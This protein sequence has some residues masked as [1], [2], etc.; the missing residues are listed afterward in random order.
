[1]ARTSSEEAYRSFLAGKQ[2][3]PFRSIDEL[4]E[5]IEHFKS[6]IDADGNFARAWAW[7]SYSYLSAHVEGLSDGTSV[8]PDFLERARLAADKAFQLDPYDYDT[9]WALAEMHIY[10]GDFDGAIKAFD[11]ALWLNDDNNKNL[12]VDVAYTSIYAGALDRA[13]ELIAKS[14]IIWDWNRCALAFAYY[15]KGRTEPGCYQKALAEIE[16]MY[17]QPGDR[18]YIV[19]ALKVRA[20]ASARLAEAHHARSK[21]LVG[22]GRRELAEAERKLELA[23]E[24]DSKR[25]IAHL[26]ELRPDWTMNREENYACFRNE[27]DARHWLDGLRLAGLL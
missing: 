23:R 5:T 14:R 19:D 21:G 3:L 10:A 15:V 17:W 24:D 16:A 1:M 25:A 26:L 7:L 27:A 22:S 20:A 13:F 8:G 9:H 12:L 2:G 18:R 6:A 11:Q 4:K